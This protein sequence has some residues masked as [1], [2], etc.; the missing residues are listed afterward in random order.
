MA[1]RKKKFEEETNLGF[2]GYFM[3]TEIHFKVWESKRAIAEI[4]HMLPRQLFTYFW[5]KGE[6]V[7]LFAILENQL[8]LK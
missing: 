2:L 1:L 4:K 5:Q 6:K 7:T 8:L 3:S